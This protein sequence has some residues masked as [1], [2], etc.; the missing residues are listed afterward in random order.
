MARRQRG[1]TAWGWRMEYVAFRQ[2]ADPRRWRFLRYDFGKPV[3]ELSS[4]AI[5]ARRALGSGGASIIRL[6]YLLFRATFLG[7]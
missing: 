2:H 6:L 5:Q 3:A 4:D 7:F 1:V